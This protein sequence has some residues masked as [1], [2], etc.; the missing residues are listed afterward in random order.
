MLFSANIEDNSST[1]EHQHHLV[2]NNKIVKLSEIAPAPALHPTECTIV[3]FSFGDFIYLGFLKH[4]KTSELLMFK[5]QLTVF[6]FMMIND[7]VF[8]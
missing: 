7:T 4:H 3:G 6:D 8:V 1:T 2:L 5:I